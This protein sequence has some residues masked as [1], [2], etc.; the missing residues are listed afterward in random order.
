M[1]I[2][3]P[4]KSLP[5]DTESKTRLLS[6][7]APPEGSSRPLRATQGT[8]AG[9]RFM[10]MSLYNFIV[11]SVKPWLGPENDNMHERGRL[12]INAHHGRDTVPTV[13]FSYLL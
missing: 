3:D 2:T 1:V 6:S 12:F 13:C 5:F 8:M 4:Q 9:V 7:Q 11:Q 10:R